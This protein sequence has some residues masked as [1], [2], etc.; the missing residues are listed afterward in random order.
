MQAQEDF[1]T[2]VANSRHLI[3][4]I[5]VSEVVTMFKNNIKFML[6]DVREDSEWA[7]GKIPTST[8]IRR[9]IIADKTPEIITD[10]KMPIILYCASGYRSVLATLE[11]QQMEY[12]NVAS[13]SGGINEWINSGHKIAI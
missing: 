11:L 3:K 10:K 13:M 9:S 8:H 7:R 6:I 2:Q 4:E 5:K 12:S 1:Y